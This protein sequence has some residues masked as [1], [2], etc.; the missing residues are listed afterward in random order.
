MPHFFIKCNFV[1]APSAACTVS[2]P[3]FRETWVVSLKKLIRFARHVLV[4]LSYCLV[5]QFNMGIPKMITGIKKKQMSNR[6]KIP[7][8]LKKNLDDASRLTFAWCL[9]VSCMHA[10]WTYKRWIPATLTLSF[11]IDNCSSTCR[12][13]RYS[14]VAS[15]INHIP[16]SLCNSEVMCT[17]GL[18]RSTIS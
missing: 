15:C 12:H 3:L 6:R 1:K 7:N 9:F 14:G 17:S 18:A 13:L 16:M 8:I 11:A 5:S 10:E 2:H 4:F